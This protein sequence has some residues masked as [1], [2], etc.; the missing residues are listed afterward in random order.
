MA[1]CATLKQWLADAEAALQLLITGKRVEVIASGPKSITYTR[2]TLPALRQW[3]DELERKVAA[4]DGTA[5]GGRRI[6]RF[7]PE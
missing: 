7:I 3:I 5:R 4:C 2:A 6:I 1:D